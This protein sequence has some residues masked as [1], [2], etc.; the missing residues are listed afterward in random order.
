M[1]FIL[2]FMTVLTTEFNIYHAYSNDI[3]RI[4]MS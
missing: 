1:V 4:Q 3:E 2:K